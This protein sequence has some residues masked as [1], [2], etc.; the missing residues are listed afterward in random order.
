MKVA[1]SFILVA[2]VNAASVTQSTRRVVAL[3]QEASLFGMRTQMHMNFA[4]SQALEHVMKNMTVQKALSVVGEQRLAGLPNDVRLMLEGANSLRKKPKGYGAVDGVIKMLNN[5]TDESEKKLDIEQATCAD[6]E[7]NQLGQ[8]E[9]T[10]QDI[11]AYDAKAAA[12]KG[13][14]LAAGTQIN[15][16]GGKLPKLK[17]ALSEHNAIC[18]KDIG[19]LLSQLAVVQ[20]DIKVMTKVVKMAK[21]DGSFIQV[22]KCSSDAALL[23]DKKSHRR[24]E[25]SL[26]SVQQSSLMDD[27]D[28]LQHPYSKMLVQEEIDELYRM[29][30]TAPSF[31]ETDSELE[32]DLIQP[33]KKGP[34]NS[35]DDPPRSKAQRKCSVKKNPNCKHMRDKFLQILS[36]IQDK[37][38]SMRRQ[39]AKVRLGCE[40]QTKNLEAQIDE[41]ETRLKEQQSLLASATKDQNEAEGNSRMKN[42]E[43]KA[44][45]KDYAKTMAECRLE[46]T[47]YQTEICGFKKIR[48]EV[49]KLE[50][51]K[52]FITDCQLSAWTPEDC[53]VTCGGGTQKLTRKIVQLPVG[54][55]PCQPLE[56]M[57]PCN[58]Q[59]CPIDC[60]MNKWSSWSSCS[61]KCGGGVKSR[62]RGVHTEPKNGGVPCEESSMAT[63]CNTQACDQNCKLRKW[64]KW[65]QCSKRC[66]GGL[67]HRSRGVA[68]PPVGNGRCPKANSRPH[69]LQ[70]KRCNTFRCPPPPKSKRNSAGVVQCEAKLDVILM[71]D[72][73]GSLGRAGWES[74]V[75]AA[76]MVAMGF[77]TSKDDKNINAR[78]AVL[79]YSGPR[80]WADLALCVNG[81]KKGQKPPNMKKNCGIFW[82]S[83]S[84]DGESHFEKDFNSLAGKIKKMKKKWPAA[85][86]LTSVALMTASD[87]L[88]FGRKG[89]QSLVMVITDGRPMSPSKTFQ[90]ARKVRTRA[91]LMWI[92]V[93]RYAPIRDIKRWASKPLKENMICIKGWKQFQRPAV[94]SKIIEDACPKVKMPAG[95]AKKQMRL[96]R[97]AKR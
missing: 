9:G 6:Y 1:L 48:Q 92:P 63:S 29:T 36:G 69:R 52:V 18:K 11:S 49:L 82:I 91:R 67:Q 54:G 64:S 68:K 45:Q 57:Q 77:D 24:H 16:I 89:A 83:K 50:G 84:E 30:E 94:I 7:K 32:I 56:M 66:G 46:I 31:V 44:L 40:T 10:R 5:M 15:L 28:L 79:I 72:G 85:T 12:A 60:K 51:V 93:T 58:P 26:I 88:R 38:D 90:A 81:P 75:K 80:T 86:T 96:Q 41:S 71:V 19:A 61:A 3:N 14:V 78:M 70:Y 53:S 62:N 65:S 55:A 33:K 59:G 25:L 35:T 39:L 27:L 87:E 23:Q 47:K 37:A 95:Y 8:I 34:K 73:S 22:Q 43:L 2:T 74:S 13:E 21:C 20:G 76:S 17:G 97:Q 42:I 4:S